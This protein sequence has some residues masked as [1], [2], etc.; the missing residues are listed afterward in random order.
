MP[1]IDDLEATWQ[2][3]AFTN[4]PRVPMAAMT[5]NVFPEDESRCCEAGMDD[6]LAR[7]VEPK[8]LFDVL[9]K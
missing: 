7:P 2:I 4:N 5:A 8:V 1:V 6:I 9:L 3:R